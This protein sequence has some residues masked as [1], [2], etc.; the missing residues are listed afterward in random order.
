M[1]YPPNVWLCGLPMSSL[2]ILRMVWIVVLCSV[3][4]DKQYAEAAA[5]KI[6]N[7]KRLIVLSS[8]SVL[9]FLSAHHETLVR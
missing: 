1:S 7:H 3:I 5:N 8:S 4:M 6:D 2:D 9:S